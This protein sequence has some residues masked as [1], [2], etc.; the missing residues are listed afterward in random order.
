MFKNISEKLQKQNRKNIYGIIKLTDKLNQKSFINDLLNL[1]KTGIR[2]SRE[3]SRGRIFVLMDPVS[4]WRNYYEFKEVFDEFSLTSIEPLSDG[5]IAK[6]L[7]HMEMSN[8]AGADSA[9]EI[10]ALTGGNLS[11]LENIFTTLKDKSVTNSF[12]GRIDH[13]KSQSELNCYLEPLEKLG[14]NGVDKSMLKILKDWIILSAP[15]GNVD[16]V[17]YNGVELYLDYLDLVC[18]DQNFKLVD[19]DMLINFLIDLRILKEKITKGDIIKWVILPG[20]AK[21]ILGEKHLKN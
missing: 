16:K 7:T 12:T 6:I 20:T 5:S 21:L 11:V 3:D 1:K 18:E 4:Y 2:S 9:Q 13:V 10:A 17:G 15:E 14:L 8:I 19:M